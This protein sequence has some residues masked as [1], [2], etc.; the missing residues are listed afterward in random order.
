MNDFLD[1]DKKCFEMM[2]DTMNK[3]QNEYVAQMA[4]IES[5]EGDILLDDFEEVI[6]N[7]HFFLL[8]AIK[9]KS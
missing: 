4:A 1:N 3:I 9:I 7:N 2:A 8:F 5:L 6:F